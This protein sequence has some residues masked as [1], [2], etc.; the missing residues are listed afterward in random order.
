MQSITGKIRWEECPLLKLGIHEKMLLLPVLWILSPDLLTP[1]SEC[2]SS[3]VI[4]TS[5]GEVEDAE[6]FKNV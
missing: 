6:F 5:A 3:N 2:G 4:S 1:A